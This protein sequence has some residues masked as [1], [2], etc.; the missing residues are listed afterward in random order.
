M[1]PS[2]SYYLA[3][4][5]PPN[6]FVDNIEE[7]LTQ[8]LKPMDFQV[9]GFKNAK[10]Y[11][12]LLNKFPYQIPLIVIADMAAFDP[13][14]E[15]GV[16]IQTKRV[17]PRATCVAYTTDVSRPEW[18]RL[19]DLGAIEGDE[20][21]VDRGDDERESRLERVVLEKVNGFKKSDDYRGLTHLYE[22]LGK[23]EKIDKSQENLLIEASRGTDK[24]R[25]FLCGSGLR[26]E[27]LT[28]LGDEEG[29]VAMESELVKSQVEQLFRKGGY[30]RRLIEREKLRFW[31]RAI[32]EDVARYKFTVLSHRDLELAISLRNFFDSKEYSLGKEGWNIVRSMYEEVMILN[33]DK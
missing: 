18:Q 6:A 32:V 23:A 5:D 19:K 13:N 20:S 11:I 14:I 31:E 1:L 25:C 9:K 27:G 17:V 8:K 24:V 21:I 3:V 12:S 29:E 26:L 33:R 22:Q 10:K 16:F 7:R 28:S 4:V 2:I 15:E 30:I